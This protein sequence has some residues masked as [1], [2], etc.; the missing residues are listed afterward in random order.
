MLRAFIALPLEEAARA[1]IAGI[2][3]TLNGA[4]REQAGRGRIAWVR[5]ENIHLTLKFLGSIDEAGVRRAKEALDAIGD[6][7]PFSL[8]LRGIG[9]FPS[10]ARPRVIWIGIGRHEQ[11]QALVDK[12]EARLHDLHSEDRPFS[13]HITIGRVRDP[14]PLAVLEKRKG[15]W[16]DAVIASSLVDRVTLFRSL[17]SPQGVVYRPFYT[18]RLKKEA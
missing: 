10:P 2:I 8:D 6:S 9:A 14:F 11:V 7:A 13:P 3:K 15:L 4:G 12:L 18:V 1:A 16:N 5:P 17:L